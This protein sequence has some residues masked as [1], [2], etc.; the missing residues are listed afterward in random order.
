MTTEQ[1]LEDMLHAGSISREDYDRLKVALHQQREREQ[2]AAGPTKRRPTL[3]KKRQ[4]QIL[5]GVCAG[6]A[7]Q[8]GMDPLL[9]RVSVVVLAFMAGPIIALGYIALYFF[10]PYD[11]PEERKRIN[12][13]LIV[14]TLA[15]WIGILPHVKLGGYRAANNMAMLKE[16]GILSEFTAWLWTMVEFNGLIVH[17]MVIV[18][19]IT[20]ALI[21]YHL[22][23]ESE[24]WRL[25]L[26]VVGFML[27]LYV[28][29]FAGMLASFLAPYL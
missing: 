4:G 5:G 12:W 29:T 24:K 26:G 1:Q 18:F 27:A 21:E 6:L 10:L 16:S 22:A 17:S 25:S 3:R 13:F 7:E 20:F 9:V 28:L 11:K 15:L 2:Q 23:T 14:S 8:L 19:T